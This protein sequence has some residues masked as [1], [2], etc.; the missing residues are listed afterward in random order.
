M[1]SGYSFCME[2]DIPER[3]SEKRAAPRRSVFGL[4]VAV[5]PD[6]RTNCVI[7]DLSSTGAKLNVSRRVKLPHKFRV[8]L[9]KTKT[10]RAVLLKWR[11]GDF[12]GVEFSEPRAKDK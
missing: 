10:M 11:R 5:A 12:V 8:A 3:A 6:L 2:T 7:R 4:A 9:L 1:F